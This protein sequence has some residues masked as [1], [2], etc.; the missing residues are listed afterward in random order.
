MTGKIAYFQEGITLQTGMQG[1]A[2]I[3]KWFTFTDMENLIL[4][5]E[6]HVNL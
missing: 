2:C 1:T 5:K 6:M 4:Q 3:S